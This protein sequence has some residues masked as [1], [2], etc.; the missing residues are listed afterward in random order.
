MHIGKKWNKN[1]CKT[2]CNLKWYCFVFDIKGSKCQQTVYYKF[3]HCVQS[4][5]ECRW[6]HKECSLGDMTSITLPYQAGYRP[7]GREAWMLR[8]WAP[9]EQSRLFFSI[10]QWEWIWM[11]T[12]L[13]WW[14]DALSVKQGRYTALCP[15][16]D[17]RPI[18]LWV[19]T[20]QR[21]TGI[22]MGKQ[23]KW[24]GI[25]SPCHFVRYGSNINGEGAAKFT[26]TVAPCDIGLW[27]EKSQ[28]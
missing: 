19:N 1:C 6:W 2:Y 17:H 25:L 7:I 28:F 11:L 10:W 24:E 5:E 22:E 9:S 27:R 16:L 8:L 20:E 15:N 23:R 13:L 14:Y 3:K 12:L 26:L 21:W 18:G 4:S